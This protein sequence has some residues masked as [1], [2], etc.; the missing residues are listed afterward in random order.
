M[1]HL[2]VGGG[3]GDGGDGGGGGGGG[4]GGVVIECTAKTSS[5]DQIVSILR[6]V[7]QPYSIA[8]IIRAHSQRY[9]RRRT[10]GSQQHGGCS[11]VG[12]HLP[13]VLSPGCSPC[14]YTFGLA[15]VSSS[16][17]A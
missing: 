3:G 11:K 12:S 13:F 6:A 14:P 17:G 5:F 15:M 9:E 8:T 10:T 1:R 4:G 16:V 2:P 7:Q